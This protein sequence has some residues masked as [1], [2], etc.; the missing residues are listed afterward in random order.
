MKH[1]ESNQVAIHVEDVKSRKLYKRYIR[2]DGA[3][4]I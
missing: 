3:C 2:P 4:K 1:R